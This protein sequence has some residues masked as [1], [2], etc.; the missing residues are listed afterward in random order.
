MHSLVKPYINPVARGLIPVVVFMAILSQAGAGQPMATSGTAAPRP[1][2]TPSD[3]VTMDPTEDGNGSFATEDF[4]KERT[5]KTQP[6]LGTEWKQG[7]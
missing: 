4:W 5:G 2:S 6:E 7:I 1:S 3:R